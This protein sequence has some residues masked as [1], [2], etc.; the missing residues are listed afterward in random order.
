MNPQKS[1]INN[2]AILSGGRVMPT[3]ILSSIREK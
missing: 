2:L 3:E 1:S